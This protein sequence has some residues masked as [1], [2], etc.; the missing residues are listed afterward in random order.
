MYSGLTGPTG[1]TSIRR[2]LL[3]FNVAASIPANATI[4][5]ATLTLNLSQAAPGS[6]NQNHTLH[7][8]TADW[9]EGTSNAGISGGTGA[10]STT[11]DAT[12]I[13]TFYPNSFWASNGGDYSGTASATTSVGNPGSYSWSSAQ[14]VADVQD[15]L[16]NPGN[17]FGWILIGNEINSQTAKKFDT[18][19]NSNPSNRPELEVTYTLPPTAQNLIINE[20]DYDQPGTDTAEFIELLNADVTSIDLSNYE[21]ELVNGSNGVVYQTITLPNVNLA[22]GDYF[23]ICANNST[24]PNCDLQVSPSTNLVQNGGPD[25]VAIKFNGTTIIDAVSYEGNTAAPYTEGSGVGLEDIG[26]EVAMGISRFPDGTDTDMNNQDFTFRCITPGL[27]NAGPALTVMSPGGSQFCPGGSVQLTSTGAS[28]NPQWLRNGQPISG[29]TNTTYTATQPGTYNILAS[30][31]FCRDSASSGITVTLAPVPSVDLGPDTTVCGS[32]LL[33]AGNPGSTYLWNTGSQS[34]FVNAQQPG[35]YSVTVT[36]PSGCID[37]D[38]VSLIIGTPFSL[39]LADTSRACDQILLDPGSV[40]NAFYNWN[41]GDTT[42]SILAT[43]SGL[44]MVTVSREGCVEVDSTFADV[45]PLPDADAGS[46]VATC[47]SATLTATSATSNVTY[48]WSTGS[49]N[50]TITVHTTGDYIVTVSNS[51]GCTNTDTVHVTIHPNPGVNLGADF[52]ACN[53]ATLDAGNPGSTYLWSTGEMTQQIS[54]TNTGD[55]HVTVT[56]TFGCIGI[57]TIHVTIAQSLAIDLGPDTAACGSFLLNAGVPGAEY[58]WSTGDTTQT[59]LVTSSNTYSVM[60][61]QNGCSSADT[62][63]VMIKSL[64]SVNLGADLTAC[65]SAMLQPSGGTWDS[66]R[67]NTGESTPAITVN[68]SGTYSLTVYQNGCTASDTIEVMIDTTPIVDLGPDTSLCAMPYTLDAG[69]PGA[70]FMWST[71]SQQQQIT[72]TVS[73]I[74]SVTV[75]NGT[76]EEVDSVEVTIFPLPSITTTPDLD[77][78]Q[79]D[80]AMLVASGGTMYEWSNGDTSSSTK[81]SQGGFYFVTV[82]DGNGC[83]VSDTVQV[84]ILPLPIASLGNDTTVCDSLLLV[85]SGTTLQWQDGSTGQTYLATSTGSYSVT[86]TAANG[87][88]AA[89]TIAVTVEKAP[90]ADF[91]FDTSGCPDVQFTNFTIGGDTY[92]WDFGDGSGTSQ[93]EDP[94]YTYQNNGLFTVTLTSGNNCGTDVFMD[95]VGIDCYPDGIHPALGDIWR[96]YPNPAKEIVFLDLSGS[97]EPT[98]WIIYDLTGRSWLHGMANGQATISIRNIPSGT[99]WI[100]LMTPDHDQ[101]VPLVILK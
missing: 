57:D 7:R 53:Q 42:Q 54:V 34:R 66:V 56:N 44:Y 31:S 61:T 43:S 92:D 93:D 74:Y 38:T 27:A 64:P 23:V 55:Y 19:E 95:T 73:G 32:Y 37:T 94:T 41:T 50:S 90:T 35:R 80:T 14:L 16:N 62:V 89:D 101:V 100:R 98:N 76:C 25:A 28:N 8:L 87:C 12:W 45:V 30:Y 63:D 78:C 40:Q 48:S 86:V 9:G 83:S 65:E 59:L 77:L 29:A 82:T 96:V 67:W 97:T 46:D 84:S 6:G 24:T 33:D 69:N 36:N 99:Y 13:H 1:G 39:N 75:T 2:A 85:G 72:V 21:V 79:G 51:F 49:N 58:L 60:V 4:T 88:Q 68:Q 20:I 15:M 26:G 11:N 10:G 91:A 17:N 22:S 52:Q 71:G 81:I 18:K 47:D 70:D 5:T 3:A